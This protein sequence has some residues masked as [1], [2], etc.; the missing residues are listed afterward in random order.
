MG[1]AGDKD[2]SYFQHTHTQIDYR[3]HVPKWMCNSRGEVRKTKWPPALPF[4]STRFYKFPYQLGR[5]VEACRFLSDKLSDYK[6]LIGYYAAKDDTLAPVSL[7]LRWNTA[8]L[9]RAPP[10]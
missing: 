2:N 10:I 8:H 4:Y 5:L 1:I 7:Y 9:P 6:R 3:E